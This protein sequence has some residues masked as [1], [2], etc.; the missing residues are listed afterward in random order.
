MRIFDVTTHWLNYRQFQMRQ[1][2]Q[3]QRV[4]SLV[5]RLVNHIERPPI[6]RN[7]YVI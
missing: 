7:E 3:P 1:G 6:C 5:H 4:T 2:V